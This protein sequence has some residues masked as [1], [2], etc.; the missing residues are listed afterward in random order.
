MSAERQHNCRLG[1][2]PACSCCVCRR[3]CERDCD[4]FRLWRWQEMVEKRLAAL[5]RKGKRRRPKRGPKKSTGRPSVSG[6][7]LT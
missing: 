2:D 3:K 4:K 1:W 5:E 7:R 6:T